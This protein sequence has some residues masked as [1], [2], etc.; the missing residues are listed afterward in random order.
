[1]AL[2]IQVDERDVN[3]SITDEQVTIP[4]S[5][6]FKTRLEEVPDFSGLVKLRRIS[7][8]VKTGTGSGSCASG[9]IYGGL[10]TK[11]FRIQIDT[12]GEIGTATFKWSDD[13]GVTWDAVLVP[14]FDTDPIDLGLGVTIQFG[15]GTGQDFN[16]DD[17]W[18]FVAEFWTEV[19]TIPIATKEF[20]VDYVTG[21]I[22]FHSSDLG[23]T[24][25]AE[26]EGRGSLVDADDINQIVSILNQGEVVLRN[27]NTASLSIRK[28]VYSSSLGVLG[29][30]SAADSQKAAIGFVKIVDSAKGEVQL[31]GP[32]DGFTG[33]VGN[34]RYYLSDTEGEIT[35]DPPSETGHIRQVVGRTMEGSRMLVSISQDYEVISISPSA[36]GS[37]EAFGSPIIQCGSVTISPSAIGSAEA[38]GTPTVTNP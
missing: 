20:L 21:D 17:R 7:P 31:S 29:L 33:L 26:Y 19:Q 4:S 13:G 1:M 27:V 8:T 32:M 22:T 24:V 11:N 23:K 38:F 10:T 30:A 16:L 2:K 36:I 5:S 14:I 12:A 15:S 34:K 35:L 3:I 28:A 25:I 6:P 9:G 37:A 18:D